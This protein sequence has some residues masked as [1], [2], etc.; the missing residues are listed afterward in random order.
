MSRSTGSSG[1]SGPRPFSCNIFVKVTTARFYHVVLLNAA[2]VSLRLFFLITPLFLKLQLFF[3][4][5]LFFSMQL[6]LGYNSFF[7]SRSPLPG[8]PLDPLDPLDTNKSPRFRLQWNIAFEIAF[9]IRV[10]IFKNFQNLCCSPPHVHLFT[11]SSAP[12]NIL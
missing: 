7:G 3:L 4:I 10:N 11:C 12:S 6:L 2:F 5:R 8:D 9:E 1:S